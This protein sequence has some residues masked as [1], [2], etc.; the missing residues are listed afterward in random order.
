ME[1]IGILGGTF[2]PIH[3]GHLM[4]GEYLREDLDLDKVLFVPTGNPPHKISD[5]DAVDRYKMVEIATKDN[6]FF[7][8]SD[9]ETKRREISYS[10]DTVKA[11]KALHP[12]KYYFLIGSDT[13]FQLKT[14]KKLEDLS[15]EVEFVVALRPKY[16]EE[17]K[18]KSELNLLKKIFNTDIKII[19]SPLYQVSS[20]EL[21]ERIRKRKSVKY[22]LPDTVIKYID[23]NN[24]YRDDYSE[25]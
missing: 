13:L 18:I 1:R 5:I 19:H 3:Y 20:T 14:W 10:V 9:I 24:L 6:K 21:R 15:R 8:V 25:L 4:I 11:L 16:L 7:E 2:N 17:N 22:L 23:A 12:A